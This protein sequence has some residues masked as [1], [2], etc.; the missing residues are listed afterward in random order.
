MDSVPSDPRYNKV[1]TLKDLILLGLSM[2]IGSG[3]FVL[4]D[5]VAKHSKNLI[6]L[7][8]I[9]AGFMS[10]LTA[11]G[12]GELS[13]I[14]KN[15]MGET[16]YVRSVSNDKFSNTMGFGILLS[17]IFILST[18][19]LGLGN[20][21][22]KFVGM[23]VQ[24]IAISAII[25]LNY[26]N[27]CGIRT[28]T[29][30]SKY[31]LYVKLT[32]I[33]VIV[34]TSFI[35][36][37]PQEHFLDLGKTNGY[38]ITTA[39]I[40]ALFAYLGFNN[41]TNFTE[42][43]IDPEVTI[44]KSITYTVIIATI[45]YTLIAVSSL[46]VMNSNEISQSPTPLAS[47]SNKLFGSYG[48]TFCIILAIISLLDTMLVTS[49]SESRYIHA[50]L[51]H[52]FPNYGKVD[53][54]TNKKTPYISIILMVVLS[55]IIIFAFRNIGTTAIYGDLLIMTIFIIVN[56]VVISLRYKKPDS[57]RKFKVPLNI[58]KIPVPS[59]MAI[60]IG[61]YAIYQYLQHYFV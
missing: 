54:D 4:I 42:E 47:I 7:S 39:S 35:N 28:S 21:V 5:D 37:T 17:D 55:A 57:P 32:V 22:S 26:L 51:S 34:F 38:E 46:F 15:N 31:A 19:S 50:F 52:V 48:M 59:V 44:G 24:W 11:L 3:I 1:L 20:Y 16:D 14:F 9:L 12:Y 6:W 56:V 27:Y 61:I 10:L 53:M 43:T 58:G 25:I 30:V 23:N 33:L 2:T 8:M 36:H 41:L 60:I 29:D 49:V 13:G 40:I 45:I 18:I